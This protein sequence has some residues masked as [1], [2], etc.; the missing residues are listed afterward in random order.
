MQRGLDLC[1][2]V[3]AAYR[4]TWMILTEDGPADIF[5]R[6]RNYIYD[7]YPP[8]HWIYRGFSCPYCISFWLALVFIIAPPRLR[9]WLAVAEGARRLIDYG[10]EK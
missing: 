5:G 10:M 1:L 4:L 3:L 7:H 8:D 2:A 9:E 6:L